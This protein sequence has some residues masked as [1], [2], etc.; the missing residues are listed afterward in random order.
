MRYARYAV[1]GEVAYGVVDGEEV[2]EV[3]GSI[4]ARS[5]RMPGNRAGTSASPLPARLMSPRPGK[6]MTRYAIGRTWCT[7]S[8]PGFLLP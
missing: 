2:A 1:G 5:F 7:R 3:R 8:I 4:F 6:S